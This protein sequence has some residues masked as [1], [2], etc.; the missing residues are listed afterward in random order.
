MGNYAPRILTAK[1]FENDL[2]Y[3]GCYKLITLFGNLKCGFD[4]RLCHYSD[5]DGG[6]VEI[7]PCS[8]LEEAKK[9]ALSHVKDEEYSDYIIEFLNKYDFPINKQKMNKYKN[10]KKR[11]LKE[12][13]KKIRKEEYNVEMELKKLWEE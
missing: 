12:K 4:W 11:Q 13:L 10:G 9:K 8:S 7:V 5:W 2:Y 3:K 6:S 1:E